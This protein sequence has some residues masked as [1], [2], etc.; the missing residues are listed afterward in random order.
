[1][2]E[3]VGVPIYGGDHYVVA[4]SYLTMTALPTLRKKH[5]TG[6]YS[7]CLLHALRSTC[8]R[9]AL[10]LQQWQ[11]Q[12]E[13]EQKSVLVEPTRCLAVNSTQFSELTTF[14]SIMI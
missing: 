5:F 1:M 3:L 8:D 7:A 10:N 12:R 14:I 11:P 9:Y 4:R 13:C 6:I 2:V